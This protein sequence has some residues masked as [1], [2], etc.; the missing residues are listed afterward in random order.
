MRIGPLLGALAVLWLLGCQSA[1]PL[2]PGPVAPVDGGGPLNPDTLE[3]DLQAS[4]PIDITLNGTVTTDPGYQNSPHKVTLAANAGEIS[5]VA[6]RA[7]A[8]PSASNT[9]LA[10][11]LGTSVYYGALTY[12]T[13]GATVYLPTYVTATEPLSVEL[14]NSATRTGTLYEQAVRWQG[15]FK[16]VLAED[17]AEP[18]D[19]EDPATYTDRTMGW[20]LP[21]GAT[22]N[23]S[24]YQRAA[25]S[26]Q[27]QEE[28]FRLILNAN[29]TYRL[30]FS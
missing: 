9:V 20:Y 17:A 14:I 25:G 7:T 18:N 19:D 29:T 22:L 28:W 3:R 6:L 8:L 13:T 15:S 5:L 27:D 24:V 2:D 12:P 1:T 16:T 21:D 23:R 26:L 30:E 11:F 4:T 10:R